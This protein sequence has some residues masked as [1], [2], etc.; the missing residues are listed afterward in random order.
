MGEE[1]RV[2]LLLMVLKSQTTTAK[3][4]T[5]VI[6]EYSLCTW[7]E[8]QPGRKGKDRGRQQFL[9]PQK[10]TLVECIILPKETHVI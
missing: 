8:Q 3:T 6:S 4:T 5:L 7:A 10:S 2:L 9:L 1:E